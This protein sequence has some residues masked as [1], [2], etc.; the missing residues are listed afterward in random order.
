MTSDEARTEDL[1]DRLVLEIKAVALLHGSEEE[2]RARLEDKITE[3]HDESVR[4][5]VKALQSE[6]P[7]ET[8]GRLALALGELL[9]AAILVVT[10]A[11]VLV[12]T[13]AGVN[14]LSS[15]VNY[16]AVR[17]TG[18]VGTSPLSPYLSF[19]EFAVG[20]VLLLSAFF[21]LREAALNLK[22][23]GLAVKSGE[24]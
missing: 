23:A 9:T 8:R 7:E 2:L 16:F 24:L 20:V 18:P 1:L 3:S 17:T 15:L 10:G 11:V 13:V 12:P 6:R 4:R 22:R 21:A 19:M 5:F 14:T